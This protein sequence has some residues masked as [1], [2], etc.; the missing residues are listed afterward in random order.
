MLYTINPSQVLI[1]GTCPASERLLLL[2]E[3]VNAA[4]ETTGFI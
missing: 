4:L 1:P 2:F 3:A